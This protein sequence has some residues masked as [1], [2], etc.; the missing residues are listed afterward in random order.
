MIIET[1]SVLRVSSLF[2]IKCVINNFLKLTVAQQ[3]KKLPASY[4]LLI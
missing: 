4:L 2:C 1:T 3:F